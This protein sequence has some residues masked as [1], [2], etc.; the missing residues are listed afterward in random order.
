[1]NRKC[2]ERKRCY[3]YRFPIQVM[4]GGPKKYFGKHQ[5]YR[6]SKRTPPEYESVVLLP[7]QHWFSLNTSSFTNFLSLLITNSL[8]LMMAKTGRNLIGKS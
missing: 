8:S 1:M 5:R 3:P 7:Q 6:D 4:P 2:F